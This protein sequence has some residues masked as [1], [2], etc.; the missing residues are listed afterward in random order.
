[1]GSL[2]ISKI[3]EE[4]P[5]RIMK[6][7]SVFPSS[8]INCNYSEP[9][10]ITLS[11]HQLIENSDVCMVIDNEALLDICFRNFKL[12]NPTFNDVNQV[13]SAAMSGVTCSLRFPS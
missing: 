2:L 10:N 3:R 5:D 1:M 11:V 4:Y 12:T 6:T 8:T 7:Y 9:Y 13:A